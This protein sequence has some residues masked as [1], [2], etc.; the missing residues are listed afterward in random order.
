[1]HGASE[2]ETRAQSARYVFR[3][4]RRTNALELSWA[5]PPSLAAWPRF[6]TSLGVTIL[7]HT[8]LILVLLFTSHAPENTVEEI[9]EISFAEEVSEPA[10]REAPPAPSATRDEPKLIGQQAI[11]QTQNESGNLKNDESGSPNEF[12]TQVR[13]S[14]PNA[15]GSSLSDNKIF[16]LPGLIGTLNSNRPPARGAGSRSGAGA[17][18][19]GGS[20]IRVDDSARRESEASEVLGDFTLGALATKS[21]FRNRPSLPSKGLGQSAQGLGVELGKGTGTGPNAGAESGGLYGAQE[22][23]PSWGGG[24]YGKRP[25][26]GAGNG[27]GDGVG[28]GTELG[29]AAGLSGDGAISVHDLIKWMQ[30][31][32]GAI[33]KLVQY[34]MEH[35]P[36]DLSSA[37][38][39]ALN[40]RR[41]E[42]F[43]SCNETNRLLRICL[44]EGGKFTLLK[45]NGIKEAS[46]YLAMGEVKRAGAMIQSL[47]TSRQAP[48]E[49]AQQ[50][51]GIFWKWWEGAKQ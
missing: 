33:P 37:V 11:L 19:G 17:F 39:F 14:N 26:R 34:D 32:P 44:I 31:N 4:K 22:G 2:A 8:V 1:M 29:I 12:A 41:Y 28:N 15:G 42:L 9:T 24:G 51:Y 21:G 47:I 30:A 23:W 20:H 7:I 43:L 40:G 6:R 3:P 25:G 13:A 48:G 49:T 35:K 18:A 16:D 36:D 27:L 38:S 10:P 5:A 45:D 50:F 46:N